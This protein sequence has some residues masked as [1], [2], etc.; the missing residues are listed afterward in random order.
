VV[1]QAV[2]QSIIE[3]VRDTDVAARHRPDGFALVLSHTELEQTPAVCAR[4]ERA[5]AAT[6]QDLGQFTVRHGAAS[7]VADE[8]PAALLAR[9]EDALTG[10]GSAADTRIVPQDEHG[11]QS[12]D[13][14]AATAG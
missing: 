7:A 14:V 13:Q 6:L 5:L 10:P 1:L 8:E 3:E 2:A 4:L 12:S 9:A 11:P